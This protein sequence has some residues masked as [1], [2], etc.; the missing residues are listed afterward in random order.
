M[1]FE[2]IPRSGPVS[3]VAGASTPV[4]EFFVAEGV[5]Q[6]F[7]RFVALFR[8]N[9]PLGGNEPTFQIR[10]DRGEMSAVTST[11]GDVA[12]KDGQTVL[13]SV[14]C[15]RLAADMFLLTIVTP[16]GSARPWRIRIRNNDPEPLRFLGFSSQ[17][18]E[19]TIQPWLALGTPGLSVVTTE[20]GSV[21]REIAIRNLGTGPLTLS[22]G[23]GPIGGADSPVV[24]VS[25][26]DR[27]DPH[28]VDTL[29]LSIG[30]VFSRREI[31]HRLRSNDPADT[32]GRLSIVVDPPPHTGPGPE[33]PSEFF[34]RRGCGCPEYIAPPPL[35]DDRS[36]DRGTCGHS[37]ASHS[38]V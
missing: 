30:H 38:P 14:R 2:V 7:L 15:E 22:D 34:C 33:P 21:S 25:R 5:E 31:A 4:F 8:D 19:Q 12:V 11:S 37:L 23:P 18:E 13:G 32:H 6:T 27:V 28:H 3:V 36:C 20:S 9:E 10:A 24:L 26:P 29:T 35:Q 17:H 16:P 1:A